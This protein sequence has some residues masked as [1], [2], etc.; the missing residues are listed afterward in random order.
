MTPHT[1]SMEDMS[2]LQ[3][4]T[5]KP[6]CWNTCRMWPGIVLLN[7]PFSVNDAYTGVK[8]THATGTN[9]TPILSQALPFELCV[10]MFFFFLYSS[11]RRTWHPWFSKSILNVDLSD[12]SKLFHF[13]SPSQRSSGPSALFLD[14][15]MSLSLC[16][17]LTRVVKNINT[18][19]LFQVFKT[20]WSSLWQLL[21]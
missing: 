12:H 3:A 21:V 6:H 1:V 10:W 20:K 4:F 2:G 8:V 11:A 16:V 17:V 19:T 18:W 15:D 7:V 13:V 14:V 5:T 9:T